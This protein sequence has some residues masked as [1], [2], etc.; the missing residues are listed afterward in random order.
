MSVVSTQHLDGEDSLIFQILGTTA[1]SNTYGNM[2]VDVHYNRH[3][4]ATLNLRQCLKQ[5][6]GLLEDLHAKDKNAT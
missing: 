4:D 2:Q 3:E 5:A 6:F 1:M